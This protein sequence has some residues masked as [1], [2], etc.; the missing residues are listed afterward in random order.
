VAAVLIGLVLIRVS[1]RLGKRSH[2]FLVGAW[3]LTPA[4]ARAAMSRLH[5]ATPAR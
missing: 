1:L 3:L 5:P 2:D 4:A